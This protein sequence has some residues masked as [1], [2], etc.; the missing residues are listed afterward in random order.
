MVREI[1]EGGRRCR[2]IQFFRAGIRQRCPENGNLAFKHLRGIPTLVSD[3]F[4]DFAS[5]S[6]TFLRIR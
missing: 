5:D 6:D 1:F 4:E 3:F 2:T